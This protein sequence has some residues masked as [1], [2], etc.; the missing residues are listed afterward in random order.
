MYDAIAE[1][2]KMKGL[3]PLAK[4][5]DY[6]QVTNI[7]ELEGTSYT[8]EEAIAIILKDMKMMKAQAEAIRKAA[9]EN[10]SYDVVAMMEDNLAYYSKTLWFLESMVK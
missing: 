7:E 1:L 2:L 8:A 10:D 6:L 3:N 4:I 5:K 9:E